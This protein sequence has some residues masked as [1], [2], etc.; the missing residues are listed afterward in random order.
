MVRVAIIGLGSR[1]RMFSRH[2]TADPEVELVAIAEPVKA[3]RDYA[4]SLGVPEE[5]RFESADAFFARGKLCDAVCICTQDA[6]HVDMALKALELAMISAWKSLPLPIWPIA[7]ASG[8]R[9]TG[10]AGR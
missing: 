2:I 8:M 9:Q 7:S 4:E 5:M 10:W 1:G 6:Q 3:S